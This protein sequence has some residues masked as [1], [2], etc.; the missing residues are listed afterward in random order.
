[1]KGIAAHS[2]GV[3]G[4]L[5][6]GACR[7]GGSAA[8]SPEELPTLTQGEEVT[9][10]TKGGHNL[11]GTL[12]GLLQ[13]R[14]LIIHHHCEGKVSNLFIQIDQIVAI[15][16]HVA[17]EDKKQEAIRQRSCTHAW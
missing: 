6:L 4:L 14:T 11:T 17:A 2:L 16:L 5:V 1:M 8:P 15:E 7:S 12:V 10:Y 13:G 9:I 3:V